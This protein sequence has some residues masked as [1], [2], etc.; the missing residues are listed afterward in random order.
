MITETSHYHTYCLISLTPMSPLF[1]KFYLTN[2]DPSLMIFN[3]DFTHVSSWI[4]LQTC[5][6]LVYW[7]SF[8]IDVNKVLKRTFREWPFNTGRGV[9]Q[10]YLVGNSNK[11]QSPSFINKTPS[12][13]YFTYLNSML[14]FNENS[15]EHI[16]IVWQWGMTKPPS[17]HS[18]SEQ[19]FNVLP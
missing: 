17:R 4:Q 5:S 11:T 1:F 3:T 14:F 9:G 15:Y 10:K 12:I 8:F 6:L 13:S 19:K 16:K 7:F 18:G 2:I